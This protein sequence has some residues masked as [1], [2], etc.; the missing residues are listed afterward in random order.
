[1]FKEYLSKPI[2]RSAH[3]ITKEDTFTLIR[4]NLYE[5]KCPMEDGYTHVARFAAHEIP[6]VNDWVIYIDQTDVYHCTDKVFR[7]RNIV[8]E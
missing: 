2:T 4:G 6:V 7:E 3:Q 1:M 8:P 5:L